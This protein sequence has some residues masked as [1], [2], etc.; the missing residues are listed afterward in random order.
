MM[1]KSNNSDPNCIFCKIVAGDLPSYTVYE[2]ED[3]LAF[4]DIHPASKGHTVVIPKFHEDHLDDL[5]VELYQKVEL[6]AYKVTKQLKT[7]LKPTRVGRVVF[8]VDV[9]HAHVL[10]IPIYEGGEIQL[11]QD[12]DAEPDHTNL[13]VVA[14]KLKIGEVVS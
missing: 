4:L 1:S 2:D 8:G 3:T 6:T 10:L 14:N 7:L 11:S 12:M 9:P 5:P 13:S